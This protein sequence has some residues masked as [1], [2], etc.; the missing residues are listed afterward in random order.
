MAHRR[1]IHVPRSGHSTNTRD[2]ALA[3]LSRSTRWLIAGSVA[4]TGVLSEVAAN[5]FPGKTIHGGAVRGKERRQGSSGTST[6]PGSSSSLA[7]PQSTPEA[8]AERPA[9]PAPETNVEAPAEPAPETRV[10]TPPA[11]TPA[12]E[13]APETRV[14]APAEGP[15]VSGGS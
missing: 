14:E 11:E 5:A 4:L 2:R 8:P 7:P 6:S 15:V 3:R 1:R 12:P 13:T 9:E 10:E